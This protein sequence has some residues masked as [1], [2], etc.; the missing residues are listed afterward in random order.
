MRWSPRCVFVSWRRARPHMRQTMCSSAIARRGSAWRKRSDPMPKPGAADGST[1][2]IARLL[3]H[4]RVDQQAARE[5]DLGDE[6]PGDD[7]PQGGDQ[8]ES[9]ATMTHDVLLAGGDRVRG[10]GAIE[11]ASM[12]LYR[13]RRVPAQVSIKSITSGCCPAWLTGQVVN[14]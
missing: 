1:A 5:H 7:Q 13:A 3:P 11:S 9:K 4:R 14:I 8:H 2:G 6:R 10:A 12:P